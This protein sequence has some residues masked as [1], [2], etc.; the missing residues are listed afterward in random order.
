MKTVLCQSNQFSTLIQ[1]K[2]FYF[3]SNIRVFK[4]KILILILHTR[5]EKVSMGV[6]PSPKYGLIFPCNILGAKVTKEKQCWCLTFR[7]VK[8]VQVTVP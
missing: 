6:L 3:V 2:F 4:N 8:V 1:K 5:Y 7:H